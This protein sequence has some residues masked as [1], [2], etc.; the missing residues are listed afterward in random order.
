MEIEELEYLNRI[1]KE[2]SE[3]KSIKIKEEI[4]KKL[5]FLVEMHTRRYKSFSNYEDLVQEGR[6]ALCMALNSYKGSKKG[7]IVW[8][9]NRYVKTLL[10]RESNRHSTIKFPLQVTKEIKPFKVSCIPIMV[11][12][13]P[14]SLESYISNDD[15]LA[16]RKAVN[17]LPDLQR[18]A[19]KLHFKF[20]ISEEKISSD[21][22]IKLENNK[23]L[24]VAA[25]SKLRRELKE[26]A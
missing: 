22:L 5:D 10:S 19:V 11:D 24:L 14:S 7:D 4:L 2:Y 15:S 8:W 21:N 16:V 23:R 6:V 20:D 26:L 1:A 25:K 9:A 17:N 12:T 13:N 3:N 18:Q